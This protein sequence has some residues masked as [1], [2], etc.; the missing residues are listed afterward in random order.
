[1]FYKLYTKNNIIVYGIIKKLEKQRR[2]MGLILRIFAFAGKY[3]GWEWV[4]G[5]GGI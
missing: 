1:M 4:G 3:K 5:V 2:L